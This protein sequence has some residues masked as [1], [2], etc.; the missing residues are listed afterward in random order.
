[1]G[2]RVFGDFEGGAEAIG[3][4][5]AIR[6]RNG[7][8]SGGWVRAANPPAAKGLSRGYDRKAVDAFIVECANGIDWLNGLLIGAENEIARLTGGGLSAT[9]PA[10]P[11][12]LRFVGR[13]AA[14]RSG[15][16]R[17]KQ[18]T[19]RPRIRMAARPAF[20]RP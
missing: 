16:K 10:R 4:R 3:G 13:S 15:A 6:S 5:A 8:I 2:E 1:M 7:L 14:T 12:T 17:A 9:E 20:T 18:P 19:A 11:E